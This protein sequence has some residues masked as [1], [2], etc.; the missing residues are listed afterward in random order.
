MW[1]DD[2]GRLHTVALPD[3]AEVMTDEFRQSFDTLID[4]HAD[5]VTELISGEEDAFYASGI[6]RGAPIDAGE[7]DF[8]GLPAPQ[9]LLVGPVSSLEDLRARIE[10][11]DAR[12]RLDVI[13]ALDDYVFEA[14]DD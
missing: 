8:E 14:Q 5:E 7:R 4:R 3:P 2:E 9:D 12:W 11:V 13:C 1:I 6:N 10:A